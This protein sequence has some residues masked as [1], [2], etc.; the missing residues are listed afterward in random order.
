MD[1]KGQNRM[2]SQLTLS[3]VLLPS[4]QTIFRKRRDASLAHTQGSVGTEA[5]VPSMET[6]A[7]DL[8]QSQKT[9]LYRRAPRSYPG[10]QTCKSPKCLP[11]LKVI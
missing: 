6:D 9:T 8:R 11:D 2:W 7:I 10:D 1:S 5:R 4:S 3:P